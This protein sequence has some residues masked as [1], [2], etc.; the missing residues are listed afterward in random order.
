MGERERGRAQRVRDLS[1][2]LCPLSLSLTHAQT[3]AQKTFPPHVLRRSQTFLPLLQHLLPS[4]QYFQAKLREQFRLRC[5][6]KGGLVFMIRRNKHAQFLRE[7]P[8]EVDPDWDPADDPVE[9]PGGA[10]PAPLGALE[11]HAE[12]KESKGAAAAAAAAEE[13]KEALPAAVPTVAAA[14]AAPAT[15]PFPAAP[16]PPPQA[17]APLVP[18]SAVVKFRR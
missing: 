12:G 3:R 1:S 2:T 18:K 13:I 7:R 11:R 9:P 17:P 6:L 5:C 10:P 4:R 16:L 14:A 8:G 15:A